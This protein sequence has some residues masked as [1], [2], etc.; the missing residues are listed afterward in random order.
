MST[1]ADLASA[2][3]R[4]C[5]IENAMPARPKEKQALSLNVIPT[6]E[7]FSFKVPQHGQ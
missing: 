4:I 2:I 1:F 7:H 6:K 3:H 5:D